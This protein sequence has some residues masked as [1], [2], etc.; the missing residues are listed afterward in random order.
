MSLAPP[1]VHKVMTE[2]VGF[3][4]GP[5]AALLQMA[6]PYVGHGILEHSAVKHD[7]LERFNRTFH[8]VFR[9]GTPAPQW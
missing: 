2:S 6:H 5:A 1:S 3:L 4:G 7:M 8:F 9:I